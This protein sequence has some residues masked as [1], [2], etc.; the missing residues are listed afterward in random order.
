M[1]KMPKP[2][3]FPGSSQLVRDKEGTK[4]EKQN[5]QMNTGSLNGGKKAKKEL[6]HYIMCEEMIA[7]TLWGRNLAKI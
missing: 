1:T 6:S 5:N 4:Q 7:G 3:G 2:R